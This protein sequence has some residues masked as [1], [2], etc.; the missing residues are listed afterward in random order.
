MTNQEP[1]YTEKSRQR[2]AEILSEVYGGNPEDHY[3]SIDYAMENIS[4]YV[5]SLEQCPFI[6][7]LPLKENE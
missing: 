2:L 6:R 7:P 4:L 3:S 5:K 1:N